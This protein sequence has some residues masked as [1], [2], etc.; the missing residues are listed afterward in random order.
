M[1]GKM[2]NRETASPAVLFGAGP[3][4]VIFQACHALRR[5][6]VGWH[7]APVFEGNS[8]ARF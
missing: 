1:L 8:L 4:E 2:L 3:A 7:A 6:D 5:F